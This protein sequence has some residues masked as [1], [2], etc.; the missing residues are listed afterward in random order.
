MPVD[1]SGDLAGLIA[2]AR[3][4]ESSQER[5]GLLFGAVPTLLGLALLVSAYRRNRERRAASPRDKRR[6]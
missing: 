4:R 1:G 5:L 3:G 2:K 6:G